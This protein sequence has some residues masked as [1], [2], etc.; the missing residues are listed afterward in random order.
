MAAMSVG[1]TFSA[2]GAL[3]YLRGSAAMSIGLTFGA[4]GKHTHAGKS[5]MSLGLTFSSVASTKPATVKMN[6]ILLFEAT[7]IGA[8]TAFDAVVSR[9]YS[10]VYADTTVNSY[11]KPYTLLN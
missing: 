6:S 4:S 2:K 9:D 10:L 1:L 7:D 5:V 11:P 3:V 8:P